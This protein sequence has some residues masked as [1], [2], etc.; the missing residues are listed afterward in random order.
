[1]NQSGMM[2]VNGADLYYEARG[3]GHPLVLVHAAI[4]DSRMWDDQMDAFSA[5]YTVVRFDTRGFGRSTMP[6]E[7]AAT[8]EDIYG[9]LRALG[10]AKAHLIGVSMGGG[11]IIDFALA[12]PDMATALI[13][14]GPG[15]GGFEVWP[16][17]EEMALFEEV[18][19]AMKA[20]DYDRATDLNLHAWVDG[21]GRKPD[22]VD[23]RLRARA[24]EMMAPTIAHAA[25]HNAIGSKELEPPA[26]TRLGEIHLPTLVIV[27]D[28]DF[29]DVHAAVDAIAAGVPGARKA[30]IQGAAHVPNME[31][32]AEFNRLVLDFLASA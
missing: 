1:M 2:A 23:P 17:A 19:A 16:N 27:G 4:A 32:P 25:E 6:H 3:E 20:G 5:L 31:R 28:Q 12:H 21:P 15:L 7:P 29:S 11:M 9:L 8:Y 26:A 13:P 24:R 10:M 14:V 30:V 18:Q 22:Q